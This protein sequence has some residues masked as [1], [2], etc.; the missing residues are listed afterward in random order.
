[1]INSMEGVKV[2]GSVQIYSAT[3]NE[4]LFEE[5]NLVVN[6][7]LGHLLDLLDGTTGTPL[8]LAKLALGTGTSASTSTMTVLESEGFRKNINQ[9][10]REELS[11][12]TLTMLEMSEAIGT[13]TEAG[14]FLSDA[15]D[16]ANTG[17]LFS[18][19]IF[20]PS[21]VKTDE[22]AIVIVWTISLSSN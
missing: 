17:T 13:W 9:I 2:Q 7:G 16:S 20:S 21:V 1:M 3:T 12:K 6:T 11:I 15:T 22:D 8:A 14:L 19:V 4:L 18:R 10:K 5:H